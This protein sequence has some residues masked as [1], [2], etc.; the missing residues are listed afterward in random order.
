MT[1]FD[2]I[3]LAISIAFSAFSA[4]GLLVLLVLTAL[5]EGRI[6]SRPPYLDLRICTEQRTY[7]SGAESWID[8][9]ADHSG[10]CHNA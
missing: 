7:W 6:H 4:L 3:V 1:P 8:P 2:H 9:A 5:E 10:L